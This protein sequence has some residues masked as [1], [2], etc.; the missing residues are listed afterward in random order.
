MLALG[1][2]IPLAA[3]PHAQAGGRVET[4]LAV[5]SPR[6]GRS[7]PYALYLPPRDATDHSR[8]PVLYLL[9][10]RGDD[11]TAWLTHGAITR[12]LD[13]GIADGK[14]KPLAVVLPAAGNSWY[15]DDARRSGYGPIAAAF[16]SDLIAGVE[17]KLPMAS[18]CRSARAVG[19]LSMGGFGALLY[20]LDRPDLFRA[21][22]SLSGSLFDNTAADME[23]RA[24]LYERIFEGV[25]GVPFDARRFLD[26]NVFGKL[27][28]PKLKAYPISVWLSAGDRDFP[29]ILAGT[30]RMHSELTRRGLDSELRVVPG[31]HTWALWQASVEPALAWL[32]AHLDPSCTDSR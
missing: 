23:R 21:A 4:G 15:V 13:T 3:P 22:F 30:V 31:E 26:W 10:G 6:L 5:E 32:S 28:S 8:L 11:E 20:A 2:T 18:R 25:Y 14:I 7:I 27:D 9:H 19:G 16:T 24:S 1:V 29:A 17:A 12:T